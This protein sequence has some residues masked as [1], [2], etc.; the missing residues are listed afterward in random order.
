MEEE[1]GCCNDI[2]D[3]TN[4]A[5]GEEKHNEELKNSMYSCSCF[6]ISTDRQAEDENQRV[7]YRCIKEESDKNDRLAAEIQ[8]LKNQLQQQT[9]NAVLSSNLQDADTENPTVPEEE[10]RRLA[11]ELDD[12]KKKYHDIAMR[13]KYLERKNKDV[14]HK[15][16][17]MKAS[18]HAWKDYIDREAEKQKLKR[19]AKAER[20]QSSKLFPIPPEDVHP[21]IPSSPRSV[22]TA[23]TPHFHAGREQSSPIALPAD[24]A[25][26]ARNQSTSTV[27]PG[28]EG[29]RS[30]TPRPLGRGGSTEQP[31]AD[32]SY[33]PSTHLPQVAHTD[34]G[35]ELRLPAYSNSGVPSSSQT[36]VDESAEH[37]AR[38]Q[39]VQE[40]EDDD[41]PEFVSERSLKRKRGPPPK[42]EIYADRS[43]DGTPIKPFRV[44]QE[45]HS[46][47]PSTTHTLLRKDTIDLD[48]PAPS[49]L[50]TPRHPRRSLE[51]YSAMT[52]TLRHQRSTSLPVSQVVKPECDQDGVRMGGPL[53]AVRGA[54]D[55][56][57]VAVAEQRTVSEPLDPF[58]SG[59]HVFAPLDPN[60][61]AKTPEHHSAKRVKRAKARHQE[62]HR[63]L[64]ESGDTPPPMDENEKQLGPRLARIQFN[65]KLQT[66]KDTNTPRKGSRQTPKSGPTKIK[67]EQ[68]PT[69]PSSTSYSTNTP[70]EGHTTPSNTRSATRNI[71]TPTDRPV[72]TLK[73]SE[74]GLDSRSERVSPPNKTTPLRRKDINELKVHDFKPNPAY[75]QGYSYAFS[76]TVRKRGDRMCLPGCTNPS[77]CGSTFRALAAAQAP[78]PYSQEEALLEDYLGDAY[79]TINLTQ[80]GSDERAELILQAR[81]KKMAKETGKHRE[82]YERRRTPPG[83]WRVDFPTTQEQQED[84]E[85]AKEQ[86]K[87][88]VQE[89]W[90][91]AQ[92]KGGKWIFRDE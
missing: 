35:N 76:E 2:K 43:S 27:S 52:G 84:R 28:Q 83:F 48:E 82:A 7:L 1:C 38:P 16:K 68:I 91:E 72:W 9:G 65:R 59:D 23:R 36:T 81:T 42:F 18:V 89:R 78:L 66:A 71:S 39:Q 19:E 17:E 56:S 74:P 63:I 15:N 20:G 58:E 22:S 62:K 87:A 32:D 88:I 49:I 54:S 37:I 86:E 51:S 77:C 69:P 67:T 12:L 8:E 79:D 85:R 30:L 26:G 11:E 13:A 44:K 55:L 45:E 40:I 10:H 41:L 4:N 60:V 50:L 61:L 33:L 3:T 47:P 90:L 5:S 57:Q 25:T 73:A 75:N 34:P 53:T 24:Q 64:T 92:R 14:L 31:N 46:S 70:P 80:M 6:S 21:Y 29:D